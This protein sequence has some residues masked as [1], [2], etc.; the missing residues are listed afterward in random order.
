MCP[1]HLPPSELTGPVPRLQ[2]KRRLVLQ[3]L[4]D[5]LEETVCLRLVDTDV[6]SHGEHDFADLLLLAMLV[7]DL[8]LVQPKSEGWEG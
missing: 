7:M 3:S 6:A 5:G 2:V 8:V 1:D 4:L